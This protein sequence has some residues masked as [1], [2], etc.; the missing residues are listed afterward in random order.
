MVS[1]GGYRMR[2]RGPVSPYDACAD[3]DSQRFRC[4]AEGIVAGLMP[5]GHGATRSRAPR[6][7]GLR[8]A[9]DADRKENDDEKRF[10]CERAGTPTSS[11]SHNSLFAPECVL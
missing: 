4:K 6:V 1:A 8:T 11:V 9:T 5:D 2:L 7:G 10:G 3:G